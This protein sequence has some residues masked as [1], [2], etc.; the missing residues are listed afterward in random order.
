MD[1]LKYRC[2]GILQVKLARFGAR[3]LFNLFEKTF[4]F[5]F[6]DLLLIKTCSLQTWLVDNC[7]FFIWYLVKQ[8]IIFSHTFSFLASKIPFA[9]QL[10]N[11]IAIFFQF[12]CDLASKEKQF[13][14]NYQKINWQKQ[15]KM[16]KSSQTKSMNGKNSNKQQE[17]KNSQTNITNGKS[18]KQATKWK[19]NWLYLTCEK[20]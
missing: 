4:I 10:N 5:S 8:Q 18:F 13:F 17:W 14:G 16:V 11:K 12:K 20:A 1:T 15:T 7:K 2:Y 9:L 3:T 19:T 6:R